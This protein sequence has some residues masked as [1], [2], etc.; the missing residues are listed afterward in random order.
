MSAMSA[1]VVWY[2]RE[3]RN[4]HRRRAFSHMMSYCCDPDEL[5][6]G[7]I[8]CYIRLGGAVMV[9]A[10]TSNIVCTPD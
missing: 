1:M 10:Y 4:V 9:P 6:A 8:L 5:S 7:V 3:E 2:L